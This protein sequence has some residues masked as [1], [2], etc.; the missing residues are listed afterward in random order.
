MAL[1]F[2]QNLVFFCLPT[3]KALPFI[4]PTTTDFWRGLISW[5][6]ELSFKISSG[7]SRTVIRLLNYSSEVWICLGRTYHKVYRNMFRT[8]DRGVCRPALA[9]PSLINIISLKDFKEF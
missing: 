2:G 7:C 5:S 6:P 3:D 8:S 4:V 1:A 9:T